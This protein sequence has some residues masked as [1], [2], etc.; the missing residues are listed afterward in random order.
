MH[1]DMPT[2]SATAVAVTT[3][4]GIVLLQSWWRERTS[5][6]TGWWGLAQLVIAAGIALAAFASYKNDITFVTIAQAIVILSTALMWTAVREFE[7][8]SFRLLWVLAWPAAFLII[9][10]WGPLDSFDERLIAACTV[11]AILRFATA[12]ELARD[13]SERLMSRWP[14]V[15]LLAAVGAAYLAWL[16]LTLSMPIREACYVFSSTWFPVI[17]LIALLGRIALAFVVLAMVKEREEL[18]QRHDALT[19]PLTGV[20]NRRALFDAAAELALHSKYLKGDPISVLVFDLDH[21]KNINDTFGHRLGD[22]VLQLFADTMTRHLET[23]SIAGRLGGEEFAAILPGA[24]LETAAQTA[25]A[26]RV[27]FAA[28]ASVIDGAKVFGTV[29]VGAASHDDIDCDLGMLFHRADGALYAA[30]NNG[31][32]RVELIGPKEATVFEDADAALSSAIDRRDGQELPSF[33]KWRNTRLYRGSRTRAS[34]ATRQ[35]RGGP[36]LS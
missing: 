20:P 22:R 35:R 11:I 25:E 17:A 27:A 18:K 28:S 34:R 3:V 9:V 4:L 13:G 31:R 21:F 36:T 2:V 19:D 14:A 32:N 15:G 1:L 23:G 6:L 8:R 29:S 16:A 33:G 30:K 7:G 26:V 12:I 10:F 24:D 5:P